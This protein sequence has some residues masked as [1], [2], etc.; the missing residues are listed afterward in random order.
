MWSKMHAIADTHMSVFFAQTLFFSF[1]SH[2]IFIM[3]IVWLPVTNSVKNECK[4]KRTFH[5]RVSV[6]HLMTCDTIKIEHSK[7]KRIRSHHFRLLLTSVFI[8]T[9][10][11]SKRPNEKTEKPEKR[12]LFVVV[13]L[14]SLVCYPIVDLHQKKNSAKNWR[15]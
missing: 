8:V 12:L 9:P 6:T 15:V 2:F 1:R 14:L 10:T 4:M 7:W 3:I 11:Q 13:W 5:L